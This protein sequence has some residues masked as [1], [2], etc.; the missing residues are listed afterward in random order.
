MKHLLCKDL[1]YKQE[2]VNVLIVYLMNKYRKLQKDG[3]YHLLNNN[4]ILHN[5]K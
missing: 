4:T 5:K 1:I 3:I 2:N